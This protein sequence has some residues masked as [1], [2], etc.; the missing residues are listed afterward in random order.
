MSTEGRR[1]VPD[2]GID[3]D[4]DDVFYDAKRS[5]VYLSCGAGYIDV[6]AQ[7]APERYGPVTRIPTA[8]GARTS[9]W[10]PEQDR[11]FVAV[12]HRGDQKAEIR[13]YEPRLP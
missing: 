2:I 3:G 7:L 13:I 1:V 5:A 4:P 6:V 8:Q 11:L 9:L 10:V 12:P